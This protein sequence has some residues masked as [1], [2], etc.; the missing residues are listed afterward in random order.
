M[1]E[2]ASLKNEK[3]Q[4]EQECQT[5]DLTL[6]AEKEDAKKVKSSSGQTSTYY[7]QEL[8]SVQNDLEIA[9]STLLKERDRNHRE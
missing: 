8:A 1:V 6:R 2:I 5:L 3:K 7:E 4:L 9:Q